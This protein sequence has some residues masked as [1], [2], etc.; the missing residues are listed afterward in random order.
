MNPT[1]I[2]GIVLLVVGAILLIIGVSSSHSVV[3]N[4]SYTW[5]GRFT[6]R[7]TWYIVGGIALGLAGLLMGAF[8]GRGKRD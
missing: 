1:R 4:L 2:G 5:S 3:D 6:E 8:G 7:T